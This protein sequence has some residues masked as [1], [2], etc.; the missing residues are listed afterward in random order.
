MKNTLLCLGYGYSA[1]ALARRL[2]AQGWRVVGTIRSE[3]KADAVR[4]DG[5]EPLLWPCDLEAALDGVSHV[6]SSIAPD[7][8]G[9]PVLREGRAALEAAR[10]KWVGYLSTTGVYGDHGGGWVDEETPTGPATERGKRRV[11]A[12]QEWLG[13][14]GLPV[15]VFRLAGIYGPGRGPF[16]KLRRGVAQRIIKKDQIFS[17]IHVEDIAS[18]L[19]ASIARPDPGRVY[20]VCDDD[21]QPPEIVL[22]HAAEMLGMV[23]P[24]A[25]PF[26]T[27]EMTP[28]ARSFYADSKRVRND[29]MKDELGVR[30][31]Y[32]THM[33]GLRAILEA[34]GG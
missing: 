10:P 33:D 19:E 27:A 25:V 22:E 11:L 9:D 5:V 17:R 31:A 1:R 18:V 6:L 32:P 8:E 4:A 3:D 24:P 29:R 23:P 16:A 34:E 12:E 13:V 15:H 28:M 20:N 21:P 14:E 7:V 2:V 30:L 26:E